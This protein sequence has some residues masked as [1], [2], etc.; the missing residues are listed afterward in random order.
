MRPCRRHVRP[1][2]TIR[3]QSAQVLVELQSHAMSTKRPFEARAPK[4]RQA[5]TSS[6]ESDG[7][8]LRS[9]STDVPPAS[10]PRMKPT[11]MPV[12]LTVGFPK[13]TFGSIVI[14]S[15]SPS[16]DTWPLRWAG[17]ALVDPDRARIGQPLPL[18]A[19]RCALEVVRTE[20]KCSALVIAGVLGYYRP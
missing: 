3:R 9:S 17:A 7:Y 10:F 12:P 18:E 20:G 15:S 8:S 5:R 11:Q 2:S 13:Q 16:V 19:D 1:G 4:A 6:S 14:R